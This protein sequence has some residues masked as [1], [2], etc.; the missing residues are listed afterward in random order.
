MQI[1][2]SIR[3]IVRGN[4][5]LVSKLTKDSAI[6][7]ERGRDARMG[8][9]GEVEEGREFENRLKFSVATLPVVLAIIYLVLLNFRLI[10]FLRV[11]IL[12]NKSQ[13]FL[14]FFCFLLL[15]VQL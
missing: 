8:E 7:A 9:G 4:R 1:I 10:Q 3:N 12:K 5:L 13:K 2:F 15:F 11:E 6:C 14:F